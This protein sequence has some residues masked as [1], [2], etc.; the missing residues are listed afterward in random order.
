VDILWRVTTDR[1]CRAK[2]KLERETSQE[3]FMNNIPDVLESMVGRYNSAVGF[4]KVRRLLGKRH[5]AFSTA[6]GMA[7]GQL[8][9]KRLEYCNR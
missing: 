2:L 6:R 8:W 4:T 7:Y 1:L 3:A 9:S 5:T